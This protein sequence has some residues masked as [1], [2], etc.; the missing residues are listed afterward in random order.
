MLRSRNITS[1]IQQIQRLKLKNLQ[2]SVAYLARR[3]SLFRLPVPFS[4]STSSYDVVKCCQNICTVKTTGARPFLTLIHINGNYYYLS[5]LSYNVPCSTI[6]PIIKATVDCI[7]TGP[8]PTSL[9]IASRCFSFRKSY[10]VGHY[11]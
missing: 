2:A 1:Q 9:C 3:T 11:Y 6:K 5:M 4:G 8:L 7:F 10:T